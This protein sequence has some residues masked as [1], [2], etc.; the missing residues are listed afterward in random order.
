MLCK[1][2]AT[3]SCKSCQRGFIVPS[4]PGWITVL[5]QMQ[6]ITNVRYLQ[7]ILLPGSILIQCSM[8]TEMKTPTQSLTM[9]TTIYSAYFSFKKL[10]FLQ[11]STLHSSIVT[12]ACFYNFFLLRKY[13]L[14]T[15]N[16]SSHK[17]EVGHTIN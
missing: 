1:R 13:S 6:Q 4:D 17:P 14:S 3:A 10:L 8:D 2:H 5:L 11:Y 7:V 15:A 16:G 12:Y 9:V